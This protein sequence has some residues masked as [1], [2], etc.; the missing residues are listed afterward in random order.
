[1]RCCKGARS[2]LGSGLSGFLLGPFQR[3]SRGPHSLVIPLTLVQQFSPADL[4]PLALTLGVMKPIPLMLGSALFMC[5]GATGLIALL[6]PNLRVHLVP[7]WAV[8]VSSATL[9]VTGIGLWHQRKW[10]LVMFSLCWCAQAGMIL[11]L[12]FPR[13]WGS[14]VLGI[15]IFAA[16]GPTYWKALR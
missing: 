10:A 16:L 15:A 12:N 2:W 14:G 9:L 5:V 3:V 7:Q 4:R 6:L 11:R 1:M 8:G 13:R